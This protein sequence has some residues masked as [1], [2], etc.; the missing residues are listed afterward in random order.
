MA[1]RVAWRGTVPIVPMVKVFVCL[2]RAITRVAESVARNASTLSNTMIKS[3]FEEAAG[4]CSPLPTSGFSP[5][6]EAI[7]VVVIVVVVVTVK[8]VVVGWYESV[9]TYRQ[10]YICIYTEGETERK[11]AISFSSWEKSQNNLK[12]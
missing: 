2:L 7:A 1:V 4:A 9:V 5:P 11:E 3:T 12:R 8:R 6:S 10:L